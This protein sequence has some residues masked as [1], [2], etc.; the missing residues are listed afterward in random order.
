VSVKSKFDVWH[1]QVS[2]YEQ[3]HTELT[4]AWHKTVAKLLPPTNGKAV[5][6]VG[7]GRGDFSIW[8]ARNNPEARITAVDFS[9]A[10]IDIARSRCSAELANLKFVVGDAESLPFP[11][12]SFNLV[13]S[14]E[15]LEHVLRP[16]NMAAEISRV[17]RPRGQFILTTENYFN[18]MV[19]GWLKS[20]AAKTPFDSGSG[21]QPHESFFLYWRVKA[22]LQAGG[23]AVEHMESN[24]FQWLL[25]P[26]TAPD[27]LCTEDFDG[28][29]WKRAFRPFGRHFTFQG[30]KRP[31]LQHPADEARPQEAEA[32]AP[33]CE[34]PLARVTVLFNTPFLYG[35]E[36][37]VIELFSALRPEIEPLFVMTHVT[38]RENLPVLKQIEGR[39]LP[40]VF[41]PDRKPW[42]RLGKPRSLSHLLRMVWALLR[43]SISLFN[44]GAGRDALYIASLFAS[45]FAMPLAAY[46]RLRGRRVIHHFHDLK[47]NRLLMRA[48]T[49][50]VTDFVHNSPFCL[51]TVLD[52]H[53][54]LRKKR[55]H[56]LPYI[57]D[58]A[59][60]AP[61]PGADARRRDL[62]M[63]GQVSPHKGVDF[64]LDAF[65]RIAPDYPDATLHIVGTCAA[66]YEEEFRRRLSAAQA[67]ADVKFWGYLENVL[68]LL[69]CAYLHLQP[70]PPSRFQE[71]FPR[72]A[73]EAMALGVPSVCFRSGGLQDMIENN[74]TGI[75]CAEES[76]DALSEAMARFLADPDF[77]ERCGRHARERYLRE[78][79]AAR[80]RGRW[81]QVLVRG[82]QR[83]A[84]N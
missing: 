10:A 60:P 1:Q 50:F 4:F 22:L 76:V 55:N 75:I 26:R 48:W 37:A 16:E 20:W 24:H 49:P 59:A 8:L 5:L 43:G 32:T 54:Y 84:S 68:D 80:L 23:L 77:R 13:I 45:P 79:S 31:G 34:R 17:L 19:L 7:C 71:S 67:R 14:C 53:P 52:E 18:G 25:L 66:G 63:A 28:T 9:P 15:C 21:V 82:A 33:R 78:Y 3:R 39:G 83:G 44:I 46:Y 81:L 58:L 6:E 65:V 41:W 38:L 56:V 74:V 61:W 42:P 35:M 12:E 57:M 2:E 30:S 51:K 27:K 29:F 73:L 69:S 40:H 62:V 47:H 70:T 72:A 11:A 64:L 36:R